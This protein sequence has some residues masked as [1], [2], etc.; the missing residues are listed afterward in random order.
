MTGGEIGDLVFAMEHAHQF[1]GVIVNP[2]ADCPIER[3]EGETEGDGARGRRR[4]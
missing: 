3:R 2:E 4:R 1:A